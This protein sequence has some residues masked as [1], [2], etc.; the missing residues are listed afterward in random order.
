MK[1]LGT[2]AAILLLAL[3]G[4]W[5][6]HQ[7]QAPNGSVRPDEKPIVLP[8]RTFALNLDPATMA[9][10][11][12]RK[13]A[14]LL[15]TGLVAVDQDGEVRPR[16]A[17]AWHRVDPKTWSFELG[18][19]VTFSNGT[20]VTAARVVASL[21]ASMQPAHVQAW[22][23]DSIERV[24]RSTKEVECTGLSAPDERTVLI[25]ESSPTPWLLEALAG[26]GGWIVDVSKAPAAYGVRAGTGPYIVASVTPD[27][28]VVLTSRKGAAIAARASGV[29]FRYLP[30]AAVAAS[31]YNTDRLDLLEID[32]PQ[33]ASL[34]LGSDGRLKLGAGQLQRYQSD[35]ARVVAF[36]LKGLAEKGFDPAA[37]R[38]FIEAYSTA[39]PRSQIA[40]RLDGLVK[41]MTTGFPPDDGATDISA[42]SS[43]LTDGPAALTLLTENDPFSDMVGSMLPA[44]VGT[45][46]IRYQAVEKSLLI[47]ALLK[48]DYDLA[49]IRL[50]A[51]HHTPRFWAAF[52]TPGNP[53]T[54]FGSPVE[55]MASVDVTTPEGI[56]KAGSLIN[57]DGNWVG[58]F[59][60]VGLY[61]A[62]ANL[63]GVRL[64]PSGQWSLE[65]IGRTR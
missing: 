27:Q 50:E 6:W 51:T 59:R 60:E 29:T 37:L 41:P 52:F 24:V 61:A 49:L 35:R 64:T 22:S 63:S 33:L 55:G 62:S 32:S 46:S 8:L 9:E 39:L 57:R 42:P 26:P 12:S 23:L 18:R 45:T 44:K 19:N 11:E 48:G 65:E 15:Y 40:A 4:V 28:A 43:A 10:T 21:C 34:V 58:V 5:G 30:E 36:N 31:L 3:A 16:I 13:V 7:F 20:P 2:L 25:R 17:V 53:Y 38:R 54:A 14:T 1:R 56:R 47:S